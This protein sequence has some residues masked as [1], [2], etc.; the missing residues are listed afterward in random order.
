[1]RR[2]CKILSLIFILNSMSWASTTWITEAYGNNENR[3]EILSIDGASSLIVSIIGITETD[4][5]YVI[6]Y[7]AEGQE[8][9][10]FD[11]DINETLTVKGS[12]IRATLI[13]DGSITKSGVTVSIMT[14]SNIDM[15]NNANTNNDSW[16][17]GAYRNN[18]NRTKTLSISGASSLIVT[19]QGMTESNYDYII[20]YNTEGQEIG[21]FDGN[22]NETL[23]VK[24]S[25]IKATLISDGSITKSGV[26]VSISSSQNSNCDPINQLLGSC[27]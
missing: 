2:V 15:N 18:E 3:S 6:I 23:T 25:S 16:T 10:R 5:D 7:N 9:G 8:V 21:R 26:T 17:T 12:S 22:I 14:T 20:I 27:L 19:I 11:G 24:G 1:M 4:Y 13:S